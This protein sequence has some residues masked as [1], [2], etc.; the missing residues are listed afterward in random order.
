[1]SESDDKQSLYTIDEKIRSQTISQLQKYFKGEAYLKKFESSTLFYLKRKLAKQTLP[2]DHFARICL[3]VRIIENQK[4]YDT[5][6]DMKN[7]I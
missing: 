6:F 2:R 5:F 4:E 7:E 1:M 3:I